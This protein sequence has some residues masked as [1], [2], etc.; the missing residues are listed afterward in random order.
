MPWPARKARER[1]RSRRPGWFLPGFPSWQ[2]QERHAPTHTPNVHSP[3]LISDHTLSMAVQSSHQTPM[4]S[5]RH[6]AMYASPPHLLLHTSREGSGELRNHGWM[7]QVM[8]CRLTKLQGG[9]RLY[10]CSVYISKFEQSGV[11]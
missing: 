4:P 8:R 2:Q 6:H 7:E 1:K 10:A 3:P 5:V 11:D 9:S